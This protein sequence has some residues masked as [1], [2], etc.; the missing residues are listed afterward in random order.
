MR[1]RNVVAS[2]AQ[3]E[4]QS[5]RNM[6]AENLSEELVVVREQHNYDE[7]H[8]LGAVED[9]MGSVLRRYYVYFDPHRH[10]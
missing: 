8:V 7:V 10:R 5:R 6:A 3:E 1:S 9:V 4:S 2:Q